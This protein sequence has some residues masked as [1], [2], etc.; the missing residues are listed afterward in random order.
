MRRGFTSSKGQKSPH[1]DL[2]LTAGEKGNF[3]IC[4]TG[5][6]HAPRFSVSEAITAE[7]EDL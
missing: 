6:D 2:L 4:L 1:P 5:S 7:R 3:Y